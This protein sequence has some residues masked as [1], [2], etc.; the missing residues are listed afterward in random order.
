[1]SKISVWWSSISKQ[2]EQ[3]VLKCPTCCKNFQI[4]TEPLITTELSSRPCEKVPSNLYEFKGALFILVLD[5]FSRFIET[6]KLSSATSSSIISAL[7]SIFAHH[8]IPDS[9]VTHN[10]PQ[11]FSS[12]FKLFAEAYNFAHVTSG[13]DYP[14]GNGE[15]E[16]AVRMLKNLLKDAK[17]PFNVLKATPLPWCNLSPTQLLMERRTRTMVPEANGVLV[18]SWQ[19]LT[20]FRK[21]DKQYKKKQK[22]Q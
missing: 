19:N 12:K 9:L 22:S 11:Y 8:S 10:G 21:V 14:R 6:Q 16:R 1:M 15:A 13:P 17:D 7:K 5:Y 3:F 4:G 18:P 20:D 2:L